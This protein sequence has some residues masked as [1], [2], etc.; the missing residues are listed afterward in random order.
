MLP[1]TR[2]MAKSWIRFKGKKSMLFY[3]YYESTYPMYL[4]ELPA[5]GLPDG[6][7]VKRVRIYA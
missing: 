6:L 5:N 1:I 3:R 7:E 2:E 4:H